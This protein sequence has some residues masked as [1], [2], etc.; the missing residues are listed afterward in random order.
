[1][2]KKEMK[3]FIVQRY[4]VWS[5][6]IRVEATSAADA[7]NRVR[8][9]QGDDVDNS[10]EYIELADHIGLHYNGNEEIFDELGLTEDDSFIPTIRSVEED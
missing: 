9:G 3:E 4:E 5:Q 8:D 2:P 1:M 7:I 10:L 6:Q